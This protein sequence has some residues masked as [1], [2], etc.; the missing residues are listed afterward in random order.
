MTTFGETIKQLRLDKKLPQRKV[1]A[2]L[3]IDTS[4]LSKYEKN[5]RQ[6]SDK[7]IERIAKIFNVDSQIL[8]FE[9]VTDKIANQFIE[10]NVD[11]KILRVAENKAEYI[12]LRKK[13]S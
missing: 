2:L 6:P 13:T 4:I 8:I 1:A 3:D 11:S 5:V 10:Q 7:L 12:K 9:A